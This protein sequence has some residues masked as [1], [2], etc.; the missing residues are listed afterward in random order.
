M[1][2]RKAAKLAAIA[3][4]VLMVFMSSQVS[5]QPTELDEALKRGVWRFLVLRTPAFNVATRAATVARG[6]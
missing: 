5:A 1:A 6:R 3:I 2:Q 4:L